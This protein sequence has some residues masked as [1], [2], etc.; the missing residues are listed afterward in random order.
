MNTRLVV[1][2]AVIV[3]A[4]LVAGAYTVGRAHEYAVQV[5]Q[6]QQAQRLSDEAVRE[7]RRAADSLRAVLADE[8]AARAEV[9]REA[10]VVAQNLRDAL[11]R[12]A[13]TPARDTVERIVTATDTADALTLC[14][15]CADRVERLTLSLAD[16]ERRAA[17]GLAA[18]QRVTADAQAAVV[19]ARRQSVADSIR[20]ARNA[21]RNTIEL[22]F[23]RTATVGGYFLGRRHS[24]TKDR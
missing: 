10:T 8:A 19:I 14:A 18:E 16:A 23:W 7:S 21:R 5:A 15:A 9:A 11:R 17:D 12:L 2:G 13:V 4:A 24:T 3:A 20:R 1:A 22:W 6:L